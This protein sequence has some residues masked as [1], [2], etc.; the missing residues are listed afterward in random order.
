MSAAF[1]FIGES[2]RRIAAYP[3]RSKLCSAGDTVLAIGHVEREGGGATRTR[4]GRLPRLLALDKD[5]G[6]LLSRLT[7][8]GHGLQ[9]A[10]ALP[11]AEHLSHLLARMD[12]ER[13]CRKWPEQGRR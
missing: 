8:V 1:L 2:S 10:P 13:K 4:D 6:V 11:A 5:A 3:R 12:G 9:Y 7:E